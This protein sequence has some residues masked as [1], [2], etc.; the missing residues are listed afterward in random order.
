MH[1]YGMAVDVLNHPAL[2]SV[3]AQV[4]LCQ[5]LPSNDAVHFSL[6]GGRECAGVGGKLGPGQ[7]FGGGGGLGGYATFKIQLVPYPGG[8]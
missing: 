3:A 2:A 7:R 6:I 5:P 1:N 8:L 4:G